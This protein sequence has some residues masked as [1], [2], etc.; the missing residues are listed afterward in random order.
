MTG[1]GNKVEKS[2]DTIVAETGI[3]LDTRLF[4]KNIIVLSLEVAYNLT[5]AL[6]WLAHIFHRD[7]DLMLLYLASLSIWSPNPGVSTMVNE[8]RVPSSSNSNSVGGQYKC[9]FACDRFQ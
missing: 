6:S 4:C 2:M 3:T 9:S 5:E 7:M 8:I 1:W